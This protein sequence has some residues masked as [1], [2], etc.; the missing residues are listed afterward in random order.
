MKSRLWI[1][2]DVMGWEDIQ[3]GQCDQQRE[4]NGHICGEDS[5]AHPRTEQGRGGPG[6]EGRGG[7]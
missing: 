1:A 6:G 7:E 3:A 4:S 5:H 2:E